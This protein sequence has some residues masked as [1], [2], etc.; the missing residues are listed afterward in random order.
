MREDLVGSHGRTREVETPSPSNQPPPKRSG[1]SW[2]LIRRLLV[3]HQVLSLDIRSIRNR[4]RQDSRE[5]RQGAEEAPGEP[6]AE[7]GSAEA[8]TTAVE[9]E[10]QVG[11][12][13]ED[14]ERV[15]HVVLE[16]VEVRYQMRAG[17]RALVLGGGV[18]DPRWMVPY[19]SHCV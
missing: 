5:A 6:C 17:R 1:D 7:R 13:D 12:E 19:T 18:V 8:E 11:V 14:S 10:A 4:T 9:V 15:L 3:H 16:G 2:T